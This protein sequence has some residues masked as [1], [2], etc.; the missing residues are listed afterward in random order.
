MRRTGARL[1][2]ASVGL[3]AALAAAVACNLGL[4]VDALGR[5]CPDCVEASAEAAAEAAPVDAPNDTSRVD[6]APPPPCASPHGPPMTRVV[7][8]DG[9]SFCIDDLEISN[10]DYAAFLASGFR[11]AG[12]DA[13]AACDPAESYVPQSGWPPPGT[14]AKHPVAFVRWCAARAYCIWAGKHLCGARGSG[15]LDVTLVGNPAIDA[16]TAA[17]S[18]EGATSYPYATAYVPTACNGDQNGVRASIPVG[19]L[20]TCAIPDSGVR[21]LSGNVWEWIDACDA[22]GFCFAHGGAFNSPAG[23]LTCTAALRAM[24]D[25][26]LGTVG[27]RCCSDGR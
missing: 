3:A 27:V 7:L 18:Q 9:T 8:R 14:R 11:D 10:D 16:W 2:C 13:G 24:R 4:D 5:G 23:E 1:A 25:G 26:G 19:T 20:A 15:A 12:A 22:N 17:C 21:D 6:A